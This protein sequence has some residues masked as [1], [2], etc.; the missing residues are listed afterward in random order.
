[1][2]KP[3]GSGWGSYLDK[4]FVGALFESHRD[5]SL[6]MGMCR[7]MCVQISMYVVV[8]LCVCTHM[9]VLC[10]QHLDTCFFLCWS[11]AGAMLQTWV[12]S[13][14]PGVGHS[15]LTCAHPTV[16]VWHI[17]LTTSPQSREAVWLGF[18]RWRGKDGCG[19]LR[20]LQLGLFSF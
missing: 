11:S 6:C 13:L 20:R 12:S 18:P 7:Y 1:M 4:N 14:R 17:L 19:S 8:C 2:G 5:P 3:L 15:A 9:Y 16:G 10:E